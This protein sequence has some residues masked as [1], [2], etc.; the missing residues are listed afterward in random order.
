MNNYKKGK[1]FFTFEITSIK[2]YIPASFNIGKWTAITKEWSQQYYKVQLYRNVYV[3]ELG[4]MFLH[5]KLEAGITVCF[6][7]VSNMTAASCYFIM[8]LKLL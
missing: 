4:G 6:R 2:S 3:N 5:I 1:N 8:K 7:L